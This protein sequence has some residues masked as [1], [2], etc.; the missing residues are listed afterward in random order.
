[1]KNDYLGCLAIYD[2]RA[3]SCKHNNKQIISI[4]QQFQMPKMFLWQN[5]NGRFSPT[6]STLS[7]APNNA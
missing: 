6:D 7:A 1:M 3:A 4:F 5:W 2:L